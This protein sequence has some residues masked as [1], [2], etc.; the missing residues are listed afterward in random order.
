M[1][2]SLSLI[3]VLVSRLVAPLIQVFACYVIFH[4]HYSPGGGFQ[5]GALLAASVLLLRLSSGRKGSQR[6]FR[7][8]LSLMLGPLGA[9]AF[10]AV[11]LIMMGGGSFLD[12]Q[13]IPLLRLEPAAMRSLA[14]LVVEVA[15]GLAVM[16]ALISIFDNLVGSGGDGNR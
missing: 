6:N 10:L 7:S 9:I 14:I 16:G 8:D 2:P 5:G 3:V 11:G 13:H 1:Q 12:Y 15:I 4:G